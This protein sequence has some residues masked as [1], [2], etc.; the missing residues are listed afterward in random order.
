MPNESGDPVPDRFELLMRL[1]HISDS[2]IIDEESPAR[3]TPADSL[4]STAWRPQEA[5]SAQL[6]DGVIRA[7]N[8]EHQRSGVV[9][10]VI[11]TGDA[12]DNNQANEWRWFLDVLDGQSVDPLSG[13]DDRSP[14]DIPVPQLDPHA[15]FTPAGLYRQGIHGSLPSIPWYAVMG[16]HDHFALGVF[17]IVEL[18]DGFR[19]APLPLPYQLA[20]FFPI[21][22]NPEGRLSYGLISPANPGPPTLL[23][24]G[25]LIQPNPDRR[26]L[27]TPEIIEMHLDSITAPSG[28]GFVG[29]NPGRTWYSVSPVEGVRL[30]VLD[31]A[32]PERVIPLLPY[33]GG[34]LSA[35][36]F[37][38]LVSELQ[39]AQA[40]GEWVI[41]ASHHPSQDL[42]P[43]G[44]STSTDQL[45]DTLSAFPNLLLH[46][47][48]H[49]HRNRVTVR[50]GYLEI[51]TGSII[52]YPQ[53][54]RIIE[55]WRDPD[56]SEILLRYR[57]FSH[58]DSDEQDG[59]YEL[60]LR[61]FELASEDAGVVK[62][63]IQ[64]RQRQQG[65]DVSSS[66]MPAELWLSGRTADRSGQIVLSKMRGQNAP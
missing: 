21:F 55:I 50:E 52:D 39:M 58:L 25:Q 2:Q 13:P 3:F 45:R 6:L 18:G 16:N 32:R 7:I 44:T 43:L 56:A 61:A 10:L 46:L 40:N 48:G 14:E 38:F 35:T 53:E 63:F 37:E 49:S 33:D 59:L 30:V 28:H 31:T 19:I 57:M 29:T 36:Q 11:H 22:L 65:R 47:A 24:L 8:R 20:L 23:N 42:G 64:Q 62:E 17:P 34:S 51:E 5:Y 54:G 60:R 15:I 66:T 26:Y 27:R 41:L 12:T 1:A 9:D 4:I